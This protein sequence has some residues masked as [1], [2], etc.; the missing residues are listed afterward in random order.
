MLI[1]LLLILP[2]ENCTIL[3]QY[4]T[5]ETKEHLGK[6]NAAADK[7]LVFCSI[8]SDKTIDI[9]FET[10]ANDKAQAFIKEKGQYPMEQVATDEAGFAVYRIDLQK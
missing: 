6:V 4:I 9:R 5:K 7:N 10:A 3:A 1:L 8:K 2:D